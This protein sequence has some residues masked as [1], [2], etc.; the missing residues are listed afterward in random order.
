MDSI[1]GTTSLID[2]EPRQVSVAMATACRLLPTGNSSGRGDT[3]K[4][5]PR[6]HEANLSENITKPSRTE[7]ALMKAKAA[8]RMAGRA[9]DQVARVTLE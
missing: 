7:E 4:R 6:C 3:I 9:L 8:V 5:G 2:K 1:R